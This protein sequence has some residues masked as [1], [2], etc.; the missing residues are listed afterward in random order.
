MKIRVLLLMLTL[1]TA[2]AVARAQS[3]CT[4]GS[5]CPASAPEIDTSLSGA[6]LTLLGGTL[7]VLRARKQK[8]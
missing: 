1:G 7:L 2:T 6:A 5:P 8:K 3:G 4:N